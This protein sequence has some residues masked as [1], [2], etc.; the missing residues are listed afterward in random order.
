MENE[1]RGLSA[2]TIAG[3]VIG[4]FLFVVFVLAVLRWKGYLGRKEAEDDGKITRV[5]YVVNFRGQYM[6]PVI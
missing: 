3:I 6:L 5:L 1:T 4:I 2:G